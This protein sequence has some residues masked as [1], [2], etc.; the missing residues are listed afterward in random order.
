MGRV[1]YFGL[2]GHAR[3]LIR[4]AGAILLSVGNGIPSTVRIG[5]NYSRLRSTHSC[6]VVLRILIRS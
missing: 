4:R 2:T 3:G 5:I 6:S 1:I